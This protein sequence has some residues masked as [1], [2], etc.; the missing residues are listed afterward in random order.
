MFQD[1]LLKYIPN[2]NNEKIDSKLELQK[3]KEAATLM[4]NQDVIGAL[5]LC[6]EAITTCRDDNLFY[7]LLVKRSELLVTLNEFEKSLNDLKKALL[8]NGVGRIPY[9]RSVRCY[10][11]LGLIALKYL[12]H[13][14]HS[15][16]VITNRSS[17]TSRIFYLSA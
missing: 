12:F 3:L 13:L 7:T 6:T 15:F 14:I 5:I 11:N 1:N 10:I 4:T 9:F 16:L 8:L 2:A 17:G